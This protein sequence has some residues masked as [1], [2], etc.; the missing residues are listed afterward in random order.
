MA[1]VLLV[2]S[3]WN[4]E[5]ISPGLHGGAT[6]PAGHARA[7]RRWIRLDQRGQR[8]VDDF[9]SRVRATPGVVAVAIARRVPL[10]PEGGGAMKEVDLPHGPSGPDKPPISASIASCRTSSRRW[11]RGSFRARAS[12]ACDLVDPKVV[13]INEEM[14]RR[15]WPTQSPIGQTLR[16]MGA[17]NAGAYGIVGV[18]ETGKYLGLTEAP[19]PY[20]FFAFDQGAIQRADGH[21]PDGPRRRTART[22]RAGCDIL[23]NLNPRLPTLQ[24]LTLNRRSS[25][26]RST[27]RDSCR[28]WSGRSVC[29][30]WCS[31]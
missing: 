9:I 11:G 21:H 8:L 26:S 12:R 27:S 4:S 28:P 2:R 5:R 25:D 16:V 6:F 1:G 24:V 10:S 20:L 29:S 22:D 13:V 18:A 17:G 7:R 31:A 3:L 14:A 15:Y 30:D 19:D 23:H